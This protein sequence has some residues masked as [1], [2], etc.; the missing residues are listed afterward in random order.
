MLP[1][2]SSIS[3]HALH[4]MHNN[5]KDLQIT[6]YKLKRVSIISTWPLKFWWLQPCTDTVSLIT[7]LLFWGFLFTLVCFLSGDWHALVTL[8]VASFL[9][10]S[11]F[12][13]IQTTTIRWVAY[14]AA[15]V[16][17]SLDT[18]NCSL[19]HLI[20]CIPQWCEIC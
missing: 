14:F 16:I 1:D 17:Q 2:P 5:N 12:L 8:Y 15:P 6:S 3:Y 7:S 13:L 11:A 4:A 10:C 20:P 19:S 9:I 18:W